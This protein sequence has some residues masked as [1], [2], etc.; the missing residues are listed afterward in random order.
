MF[1]R[2]YIG[3]VTVVKSPASCAMQEPQKLGLSRVGD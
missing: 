1:R 3:S 2:F